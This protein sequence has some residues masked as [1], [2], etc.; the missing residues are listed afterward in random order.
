MLARI[1]SFLMQGIDAHLCEVEIDHDGTQEKHT[2]LVVGLPDA[3]VKESLE[4]VR[5]ALENSS[6]Q[7]PYGRV[8]VSLAPADV[9][10]EGPAYDLAI[11]LGLLISQGVIRSGPRPVVSATA[12]AGAG[13]ATGSGRSKAAAPSYSRS[14]TG[15]DE[16]EV[17]TFDAPR[18]EPLGIGD[19][20]FA[21]ELALDGRLRPV[22]G[23]IAMAALAKS[24]G[25][26]GVV[27]PRDNAP[28]AAV[29]PGV[30]AIG[31]AT[32]AEVVGYLTGAVEPSPLPTVDVESLLR[33]A[34]AEIDFAEVRGQ[35]AVKRAIVVA[36]AGGHNLLMLG[37]AGTGKSMMAKA[38]PGVLPA[39]TAEEAVEITRIYSAAG[40]MPAG[41]GLITTRP[42]RTPHHTASAPAIIGGGMIPRPGE[43]SLAHR[44]VMF[45]DELPEF[46]RMVLETLRQPLEDHVVTIA[47]AHSAV[48]FPANFML[49]AA[50]NPTPKGDFAQDEFGRREMERYLSR[51]SG[52]LIDRIDIHVEAPA[53]PFKQLAAAPR[54]TSTAD[55][56]S[57]AERARAAQIARQGPGVPNARLSGKQLDK[58]AAMDDATR[59]MLG[60]AMGE[61]GL[62]ARAYDKIRRVA[63]TIADLAGSERVGSEHV[64]EAIGYRLLDR[65]V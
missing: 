11:A 22:K 32:L 9:R 56:R 64:S 54:G 41:A 44:G 19:Y 4:R 30:E 65:K 53:V 20:L 38:L 7:F 46:P 55:M 39:L 43:I 35:E 12:R 28:E 27:V 26:R 63:R 36:A 60:R 40:M 25:L 57:Q 18:F 50:M 16:D 21:G 6:Y 33:T 8:L 34:T 61:L 31:A 1:G 15:A 14:G 2:Q 48:R 62:S 51:L 3:A 29:V 37:P 24:L 47:R 59:D 5:S 10:K 13:S 52:P 58:V 42:V 23:V 49:V 17:P 45:L